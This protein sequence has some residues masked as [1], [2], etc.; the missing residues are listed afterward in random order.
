MS[1]RESLWPRDVS[2][3][4]SNHTIGSLLAER[5]E[6]FDETTALVGTPH[7]TK[8]LRRLTYRELYDEARRVTAALI[9]MAAP[10][11]SIAI[12]EADELPTTPTG[13]VQKFRLVEQIKQR[14]EIDA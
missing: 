2:V 14:L 9:R 13:K 8:N 1:L 7:G 11:D 5:A 10:G 12:W 6:K 3:E 4:S